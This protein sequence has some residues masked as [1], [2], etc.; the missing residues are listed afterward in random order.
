MSGPMPLTP[1]KAFSPIVPHAEPGRHGGASRIIEQVR[2]LR[3]LEL[4][5]SWTG[6]GCV[7][8]AEVNGPMSA[9]VLQQAGLRMQRRYPSLRV[10]CASLSAPAVGHHLEFCEPD[11]ERF[12]VEEIRPEFG[13]D[14][15]N[16]LFLD[17][18]IG[19]QLNRRFET[20][21][22]FMFRVAWV[23]NRNEGGHVVACASEVV[24]D[25]FSLI[26]LYRGLLQE[27]ARIVQGPAPQRY[28][29]TSL[30]AE[31]IPPSLLDVTQQ[32]TRAWFL[33]SVGRMSRRLANAVA[34]AKMASSEAQRA[35]PLVHRDTC[36]CLD[37]D[38]ENYR[39]LVDA[40]KERG[41]ELRYLIGAAAQFSLTRDLYET[42]GSLR[43]SGTPITMDFDLRS[44]LD[45]KIARE[46]LGML[47]GSAK[48]SVRAPENTTLWELAAVLQRRGRALIARGLPVATHVEWERLVSRHGMEKA[49]A[50]AT[51]AIG[52]ER[53]LLHIGVVPEHAIPTRYGPLTLRRTVV[54]R[55]HSLRS[56]VFA[57]WI[58]HQDDRLQYCVT[59]SDTPENQ[60]CGNTL[61]NRV[62]TLVENCYRL[63]AANLKLRDYASSS[64]MP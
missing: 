17:S 60:R 63:P 43:F 23:P 35:E 61:L 59:S 14:Q 28:D 47:E 11:L 36:R 9:A 46:Q 58:C 4:A 1:K 31:L 29:A 32:S 57:L 24:T 15:G 62:R 21:S 54:A 49:T 27:C 7:I 10:R 55:K 18:V 25:S 39:R 53:S 22:G 37:G 30:D 50:L 19:D 42:R 51:A 56:A 41:I 2:P 40:A 20:D 13:L 16:P 3:G 33:A 45:G 34:Q 6:D 64:D 12:Q 5:A 52:Q 48:I 8:G 44:E 26:R 38:P